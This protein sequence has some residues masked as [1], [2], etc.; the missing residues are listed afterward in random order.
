VHR[1]IAWQCQKPAALQ[2]VLVHPTST[3]GGGGDNSPLFFVVDDQSRVGAATLEKIG[4][5]EGE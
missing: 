2:G 1:G 5:R 4:G 3:A